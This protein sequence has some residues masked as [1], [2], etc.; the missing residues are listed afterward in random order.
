MKNA[1]TYSGRPRWTKQLSIILNKY[2]T[3]E[4]GILFKFILFLFFLVTSLSH[5]F[6]FFSLDF[7]SFPSFFPF[8]LPCPALPLP[9]LPLPSIYPLVSIP[10]LPSWYLP[11]LSLHHF[12][13][14]TLPSSYPPF[15]VPSTFLLPSPHL[16]PSLSGS[17]PY[18]SLPFK[19]QTTEHTITAIRW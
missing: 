12:P 5:F 2:P 10:F 4:V 1:C 3:R 13:Q 18:P 8:S 14:L 7:V 6:P 9:P 17:R 15:P 11:I 19:N 16:P